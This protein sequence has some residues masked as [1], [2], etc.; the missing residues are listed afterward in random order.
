MMNNAV[1]ER[2]NNIIET[3]RLRQLEFRRQID[4]NDPSLLYAEIGGTIEDFGYIPHDGDWGEFGASIGRNT[5]IEEVSIKM[6]QGDLSSFARGFASN[7]SVKW[8]TIYCEA[9]ANG[10]A[11]GALLPF[12]INNPVFKSLHIR[13]AEPTCLHVLASV[14]RQFDTLTEFAL[15]DF[16]NMMMTISTKT[17]NYMTNSMTAKTFWRHSVRFLMHWL[18]IQV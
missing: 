3:E 2:D 17:M 12:F 7:R 6:N 9:L 8:I 5:Y 13:R 1:D 4:S 11:L 15:Y 16:K 14:L 18:V 10:E